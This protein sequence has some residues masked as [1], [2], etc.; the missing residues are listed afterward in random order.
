MFLFF[1]PSSE[2][3]S[4]AIHDLARYEQSNKLQ[5]EIIYKLYGEDRTVFAVK[6]CLLFVCISDTNI[7]KP[8]LENKI[9][10]ERCLVK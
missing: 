6:R 10:I 1:P 9:S 5:R 7:I 4:M 3:T 2:G 8:N